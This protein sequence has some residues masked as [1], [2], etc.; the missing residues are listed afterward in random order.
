MFV[1]FEYIACLLLK[2]LSKMFERLFIDNVEEEKMW[3]L[4][5]KFFT[6]EAN[7]TLFLRIVDVPFKLGWI[8]L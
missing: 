3:E 7:I 2:E 5:P 1:S 8:V 6:L 4:L